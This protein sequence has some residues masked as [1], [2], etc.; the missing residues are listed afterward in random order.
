LNLDG[1]LAP[2]LTAADLSARAERVKAIVQANHGKV[3]DRTGNI[4]M[5]E[6]PADI[7]PCMASLWGMGG[8]APQFAPGAAPGRHRALRRSRHR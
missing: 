4:M 2:L 6:I 8:F 3:I 7:A 1:R 5:V